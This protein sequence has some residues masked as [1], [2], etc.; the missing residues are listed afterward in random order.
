MTRTSHR[1]VR[2]TSSWSQAFIMTWSKS[3]N[4]V[5]MSYDVIVEHV[6]ISW[7]PKVTL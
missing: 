3:W 7:C 1:G 4:D 6:M 5:V 2:I